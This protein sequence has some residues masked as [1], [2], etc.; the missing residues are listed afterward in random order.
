MELPP[1]AVGCPA[2][3]R[4]ALE[5]SLRVKGARLYNLLPKELREQDGCSVESFK[6]NLDTWLSIVPD[7]PTIPG[8]Q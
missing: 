1:F 8:I 3:V 5:T 7:Q 4:N 6:A 2:S